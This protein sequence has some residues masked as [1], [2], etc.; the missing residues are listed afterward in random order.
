M[1]LVFG[2]F[3][4]LFFFRNVFSMEMVCYDY[5]FKGV[6]FYYIY[7]VLVHLEINGYVKLILLE[8]WLMYVKEVELKF[9]F[10]ILWLCDFMDNVIK[11]VMGNLF[12]LEFIIDVDGKVVL[13][14]FWSW[15]E[16]LWVDLVKLVGEVKLVT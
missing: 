5:V 1:V 16:E 4:W 2:C 8:E 9:G 14:R 11:Y 15:S 6:W 13:C 7:K 12:N 10:K 3:M